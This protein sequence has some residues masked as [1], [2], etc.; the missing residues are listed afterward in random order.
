MNRWSWVHVD[1]LGEAYV[2]IAKVG[3]IVDGQLFNL[4]ANDNPTYDELKIAAAKAS[5]WKN[6][7]IKY[8][9][10][11]EKKFG[12]WGF[13]VIIN[14][15]KVIRC[16]LFITIGFRLTWLETSSCWGHSRNRNVFYN[17]ETC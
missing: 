5:G 15:E 11:E 12:V 17:L 14:P 8:V 4:A 10:P 9:S 16:S 13:N 1:D 7:E 2:R 6:G 3:N